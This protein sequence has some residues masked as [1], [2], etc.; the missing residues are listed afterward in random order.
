PSGS[1]IS[2]TPVFVGSL[3]IARRSRPDRLSTPASLGAGP[4]SPAGRQGD[5][6]QRREGDHRRQ[7]R[8]RPLR[9]R[10]GRR[11]GVGRGG[12]RRRRGGGGRRRGRRGAGGGGGG[13]GR[14]G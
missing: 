11:A 14:G 8:E 7:V 1:L 3:T 4:R 6:G 9:S 5:R 12:W 13:A 10:F 2:H